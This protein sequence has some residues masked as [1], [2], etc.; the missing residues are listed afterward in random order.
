VKFNGQFSTPLCIDAQRLNVSAVIVADDLR[1]FLEVARTG[2]LVAAASR[3]LV[4]HT[5]VSRRIATLERSLGNRLFDRSPAGWILTD[6]GHELLTHAE[7]IESA[8]QAAMEGSG[9]GGPNLSGTVRISTPDGFGAFVLL[10]N[11]A[12]L[13]S[14]HPDLRIE[15]VTETRHDALAT[16]QFDLAV[17]LERPRPRAV[18]ISKLADYQLGL[19]ATGDYLAMHGRITGLA[20]LHEHTLIGYVDAVLEVPPAA[21]S[22]RA[23]ARASSPDSDQQHCRSMACGRCQ[24]GCGRSSGVHRRRGSTLG[25]RGRRD[26][27]GEPDVLVSRTTRHSATGSSARGR[28]DRAGNRCNS[29]RIAHAGQSARN[30]QGP[31]GLGLM[32]GAARTP[33][34]GGMNPKPHCCTNMSEACRRSDQHGYGHAAVPN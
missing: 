13:R 19:Y 7:S 3:L 26:G 30:T 27:D 10:P 22:R 23:G 20:D 34:G 2:R 15:I 11:L 24:P 16:R 6:A 5:T 9:S 4:N 8:L 14:K 21:H 32:T 33:W 1:Y 29:P 12:P 31:L 17:T 18:E 25:P 28:R